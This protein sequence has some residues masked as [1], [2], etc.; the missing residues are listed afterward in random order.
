MSDAANIAVQLA[1][2]ALI[3]LLLPAAYRVIKGPTLADRLQATDLIT[4]MLIG[5][6]ALLALVQGTAFII[7]VAIALAAFS[8]VGTVAIARYLSE[9]R[10]F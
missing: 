3:L 2:G 5:I 8:F 1:L 4:T 6:I 7:D 9:G 10:V